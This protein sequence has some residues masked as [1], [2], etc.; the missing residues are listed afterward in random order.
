MMENSNEEEKRNVNEES[1][2]DHQELGAHTR[3]SSVCAEPVRG[4]EDPLETQLEVRC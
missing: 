2:W 4:C 3:K 1:T